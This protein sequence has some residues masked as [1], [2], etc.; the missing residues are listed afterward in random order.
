[1]RCT[2]G[3]MNINL[4]RSNDHKYKWQRSQIHSIRLPHLTF[5]GANFCHLKVLV[6]FC[7]VEDWGP[8]ADDALIPGWQNLAAFRGEQK[9]Q[10]KF[11]SNAYI[12]NF[13]VKCV[14]FSRNRKFA[15]LTQWNM[16]YIPCNI[17]L[18]AQI[19]LFWTK[20]ISK[21]CVNHDISS[22]HD[23]ITYVRASSNLSP[24]FSAKAL[25][26]FAGWQNLAAFRRE[27]KWQWKFSS[28]AYLQ[29]SRHFCA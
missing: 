16:Q 13:R 4:R 1:M 17:A 23:A 28:N 7:H 5:W 24:N 14:F 20:K 6:M 8:S 29:F 21:K 11:S 26:A 15:K 2:G 22:Y 18:L 19:T 27:Q 12:Y 10:W 25:R 9:W 3:S